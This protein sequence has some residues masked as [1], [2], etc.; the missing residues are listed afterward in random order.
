MVS[1]KQELQTKNRRF[2]FHSE[3]H[4]TTRQKTKGTV[5]RRK[6]QQEKS[7]DSVEAPLKPSPKIPSVQKLN[8]QCK[9]GI[10][11]KEQKVLVSQ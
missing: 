2:W 9:A 3:R 5:R 4:D 6:K 1:A 7:S 10:A 8:G 11:N